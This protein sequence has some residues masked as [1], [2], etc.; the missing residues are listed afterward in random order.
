[1]K[2]I[3]VIDA[4]RQGGIRTSFFNLINNID[5]N[6]YDISLFSFHITEDDINQLPKGLNVILPNS[7]FDLAASTGEEVY[8]KSKSKYF[9]RKC[10]ALACKVFNSD[11]IYDIIFKT[12]NR[13]FNY[14]V[15]IS[16][17]NNVGDH[18]LY[19]GSNKFVLNKISS[20]KKI[21]WIHANY[22]AMNLDTNINNNEY[23]DFDKIIAVSE[24]TKDQFLKFNEEKRNKVCVIYNLINKKQLNIKSNENIDINISNNLLNFITISRIDENKDLSKAIDISLYL[25]SKGL[26]FKWLILGDGPLLEQLI[27]KT[28]SY[29]LNDCIEWYGYVNNPYPLLKQSDLYISTSKSEGYSLSIVE[30]L[31][32]SI[33]VLCGYYPSAK[34]CISNESGW[35]INNNVSSYCEFLQDLINNKKILF[36]KKRTVS[37]LHENEEILTKFEEVLNG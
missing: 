30:A 2:I 16:F 20:K 4:L 28:N 24:E 18:S 6:K 12:E 1:M 19:F 13:K 31:F 26:K 10:L 8:K 3:F 33:P 9:F 29:K 14:D 37:I 25:K 23:N 27:E 32:F 11:R 21:S 7:L 15:A 35:I 17:T 36:D 22:E 5:L 34:E